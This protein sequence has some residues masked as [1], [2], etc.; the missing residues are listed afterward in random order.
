MKKEWYWNE[1]LLTPC[2]PLTEMVPKKVLYDFDGP[3]I[4]TTQSLTGGMLLAYL[5]EDFDRE[6]KMR[7]LVSLTSEKVVEDLL[8]GAMSVREALVEEGPLLWVVD[9]DYQMRPQFT[10]LT[11]PSQLPEESLPGE[12]V[13]LYYELE[14]EKQKKLSSNPF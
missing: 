9:V 6:K 4:F 11:L 12:G 7:Y 8:T 5:S 14:A 1:N 13:L 3:C 2:N 10:F